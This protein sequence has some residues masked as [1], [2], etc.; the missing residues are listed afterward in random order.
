MRRERLESA[1]STRTTHPHGPQVPFVELSGKETLKREDGGGKAFY[2]GNLMKIGIN[3]PPTIVLP[4]MADPIVIGDAIVDWL[5]RTCGAPPWS[6]AVRSSSA[7]ED[8]ETSSNA[9][10]FVSRLGT[11]DRES[12][13]SAVELVRAS[14]PSMAVIFQPLID[15]RYAGVAFSCAPLTYLRNEFSVA[16]TS[17]LADRL[18]AGEERGEQLRMQP[19][20]VVVQ[21]NWPATAELLEEFAQSL[22]A[23]ESSFDAPV[24]VEWVIDS[25]GRLWIV[26]ARPVVLPPSQRVALD[27]EEHFGALPPLV[28]NH[29]KIRLRRHAHRCDVTMAPAIAEIVSYP[30]HPSDAAVPEMNQAAGVS[31]VLL[32]PERIN[33]SVIR[34]FSP[35]HGYDVSFFTRGCRRYS[36]RRYPRVENISTARNFVLKAG[37]AAAWTSISIVQAIWSA[38]AT[39]IVRRTPDCYV[40]DIA[41]GHFV[42]KGVVATSTLVLSRERVLLSAV[43]R[44]QDTV[45]HFVD[46]HVITESPPGSQLRL[47]DDTAVGVATAF[48]PI[49]DEYPNAALEFGLIERSP[50]KLHPYLIDVAEGDD[51]DIGLNPELINSGVLSVGH[52]K[53]RLWRVDSSSKSALDS[54]FHNRPDLAQLNDEGLIVV[55]ERA[56]VDLLSYVGAPG[57][58]GFVFGQGSVL[59]H[60]AV[61]IREKGLPAV[62]LDDAA[63]FSK[64]PINTVV[65]LDAADSSLAPSDRVIPSEVK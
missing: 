36:V 29:P 60:L 6:L 64:L 40:I 7:E 18:V 63:A 32:H 14:G 21:G 27:S 43:W 37:L 10:H 11:F 1:I 56:T 34:E 28:K 31:V 24:D 26:Q 33:D 30:S 20:G 62:S 61:V 22:R 42:P 23:I 3:V 50:G 54:H 2:L 13:T 52:C 53:G 44:D 45:Y 57:V 59:A 35:V 55:A 41:L 25:A 65:T 9:G 5:S 38:R 19:N 39:G 47:D 51:G 12:I 16:W 4:E 58:V 17:G 48:D 46:G 49:F 8:T 15:A